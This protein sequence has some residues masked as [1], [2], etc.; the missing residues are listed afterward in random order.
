MTSYFSFMDVMDKIAVVVGTFAFGFVEQLTGGIRYSAL[1]LSIFFIIG[2][3]L[4]SK[5]T[6]KD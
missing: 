5:V 3:L 1:S 2:M 4:L 6:I